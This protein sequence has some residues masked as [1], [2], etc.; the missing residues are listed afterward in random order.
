MITAL[1]LAAG[2]IAA[3]PHSQDRIQDRVLTHPEAA[4][5]ATGAPVAGQ[6]IRLR[7]PSEGDITERPGSDG[8]LYSAGRVATDTKLPIGYPRP[9]PPGAVEVK[10]YGTVRQAE[11]SGSSDPRRAS[12]SGFMPLFGH[13]QRNSIAMTAPVEMR[14][15]DAPEPNGNGSTEWTMAFLYHT[16]ADGPTGRD[17]EVRVVD[18]EPLTVVALGVR[19]GRGF[20]DLG[21]ARA[22]LEAVIAENTQWTATGSVRMLGYNGPATPVRDRWWELQIPVSPAEQPAEPEAETDPNRTL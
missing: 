8:P 12:R 21:T 2:S 13:I 17:G 22:E 1:L 6:I 7:G 18:T 16:E 11:F 19:G 15:E 4:A 5:I 20:E 10:H 14:F 9:T 3:Q